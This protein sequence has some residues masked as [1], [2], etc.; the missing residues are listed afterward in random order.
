V[1]TAQ[2]REPLRSEQ[3]R[4]GAF[5]GIDEPVE[6]HGQ[7]TQY[8][9]NFP[10]SILNRVDAPDLPFGMEREPLPGLR[11]RMRL[12][13]CAA[14]RHEYWGLWRGPGLRTRGA[15]EAQRAFAA[16]EVPAVA[17][18]GPEAIMLSGNTDPYQPVERGERHHARPAWR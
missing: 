11:A 10:Q 14:Q 4:G 7:A 13:L 15:V 17:R 5:E 1:H 8:L 16:G 9:E 18:L 12:L 3:L 2:V 6:E